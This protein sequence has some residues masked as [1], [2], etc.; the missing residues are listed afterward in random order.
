MTDQ[1][2]ADIIWVAVG[3]VATTSITHNIIG[4]HLNRIEK[5]IEELSNLVEKRGEELKRAAGG[6]E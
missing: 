1:D 6:G 4:F 2:W 5:R 3:V